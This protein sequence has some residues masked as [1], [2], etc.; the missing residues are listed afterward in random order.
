MRA[1]V[2]VRCVNQQTDGFVS[3][4]IFKNMGRYTEQDYIIQL[5]V[6]LHIC[7]GRVHARV[8]RLQSSSCGSGYREKPT[9]R[10]CVLNAGSHVVLF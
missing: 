5:M 4:K 1:Q 9:V 3:T 2:S 7:V 10:E 6:R 8:R